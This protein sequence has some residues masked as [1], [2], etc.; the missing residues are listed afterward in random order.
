VSAKNVVGTSAY[1][2]VGSGAIILSV[3]SEPQFLIN[4]PSVTSDV[5]IGLSW[6]APSSNG[7]TAVIDYRVF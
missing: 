6:T 5:Q 2:S 3:P 1:S 7:G 4:V